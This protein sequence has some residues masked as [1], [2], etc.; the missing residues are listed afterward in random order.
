VIKFA[1]I[2]IEIDQSGLAERQKAEMEAMIKE[3]A[4]HELNLRKMAVLGGVLHLDL[5]Q[6]PP[7]PRELNKNLSLTVCKYFSGLYQFSTFYL[8]SCIFLC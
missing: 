8:I 1:K 5:L 2:F 6:Q 4:P 7:Q 3:T